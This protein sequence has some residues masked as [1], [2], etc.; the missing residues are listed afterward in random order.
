M[1]G[2]HFHTLSWDFMHLVYLGTA[3]DLCASGILVLV[4]HGRFAPETV[5]CEDF[6]EILSHVQASMRDKCAKHGFKMPR[7]PF[8]TAASLGG[9]D[10][11]AELGSR[12]K[13][14]HIKLMIWWL[15]KESQEFADGHPNDA[16][17]NVLATSIYGLQRLIEIMDGSGL[18]FTDEEAAEASNCLELHLKSYMW[19]AVYFYERRVMYFKVRCKTHYLFHLVDEIRLWKLNPVIWENFEEESFLG[20]LKRIAIRCHGGTCTQRVFSRYLL[21]LAMALRDFQKTASLWE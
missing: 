5:G 18:V 12:F 1:P 6:D 7:K 4:D 2:F 21:C 15:A 13:A 20:K 9:D 19:L 8:L 14:S 3:R 16:V 10:G 17:A 11:Y